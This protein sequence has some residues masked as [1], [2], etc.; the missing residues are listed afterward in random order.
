[1]IVV[2][3]LN[4]NYQGRSNQNTTFLLDQ[5]SYGFKKGEFPDEN[6]VLENI[7]SFEGVQ[8]K[9]E[10]NTKVVIENRR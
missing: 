6:W 5:Y 9:K 8:I 10:K 3:V 7:E 1:M 2:K 4:C